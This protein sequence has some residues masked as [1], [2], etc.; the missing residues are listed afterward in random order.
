[1][2]VVLGLCSEVH[3]IN[4]SANLTGPRVYGLFISVYTEIQE[5]IVFDRIGM[6]L[7]MK[8]NQTD[9][10]GKKTQK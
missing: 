7:N 1:M 2:S 5:W 10:C 9:I 8:E 3:D 4:R 6:S